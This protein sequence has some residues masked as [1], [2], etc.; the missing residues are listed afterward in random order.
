M[1][2]DIKLGKYKHYKGKTCEVIGTANHSEPLEQ[3][4]VYIDLSDSKEFGKNAMWVR[5]LE[6]FKEEI[7]VNG[8]MVPRFK[9]I[10]S[11]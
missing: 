4:V 9:Y 8:E 3:L 6:I 7:E 1:H 2:K 5:P 11:K 10:T